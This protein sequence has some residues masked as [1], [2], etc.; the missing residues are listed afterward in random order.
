MDELAKRMGYMRASSIQRY[1]SA[2]D[3]RGE[4]LSPSVIGKLTT[5]LVGLGTPPISENEILALGAPILTQS[6]KNTVPV[7]S[8]V[9]AGEW[10]SFH[11]AYA[12]G[13]GFDVISADKTIG[14]NAFAL[15]I[16]G[17]SM[18]PRFLEG[19]RVI[20]DPKIEPIPGDFV[21]ASEDREGDVVFKQYR[22]RGYDSEH[23]P[24]IELKPLNDA[25]PTLILDANNPGRIIGT[26]VEHHSYRKP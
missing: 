16:K 23:R 7:I 6:H 2:A 11:D 9:Q 10:T 12:K 8:Y 15:E 18:L 24:I 1:E 22:P 14:E 13:N 17:T 19:D 20:V 3:F 25:W 4:Y 5:A 26:M 21:V